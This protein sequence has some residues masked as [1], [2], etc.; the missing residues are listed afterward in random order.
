MINQRIQVHDIISQRVSGASTHVP[1]F[2]LLTSLLGRSYCSEIV[3]GFLEQCQTLGAASVTMRVDLT[4][5]TQQHFWR[6]LNEMTV[7][8]IAAISA[9]F[10]DTRLKKLD[11]LL[12]ARHD[13]P[14]IF[15]YI[16]FARD[17]QHS[18]R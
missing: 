2:V 1:T 9:L 10:G 5:D 17:S 12:S 8:G 11:A 15:L 13:I 7:D 4:D 3:R 16:P 18:R 14:S 6:S